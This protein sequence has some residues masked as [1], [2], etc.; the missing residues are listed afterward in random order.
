MSAMEPDRS[1]DGGDDFLAAEF[2]LGV[3]P[4][5][6]LAALA[7]RAE[8]DPAFARAVADW[9]ERLLPLADGYAPA[10]LPPG[11]KQTLD[12]HL[13]GIAGPAPRPGF[14]ASLAL[15]RGLAGTA[16]AAFLLALIVPQLM[17]KPAPPPDVMASLSAKASDVHYMAV[18]DAGTGTVRLAHMSGTPAAGRVFELWVVEGSAA[19]VSL[20]VIPTGAMVR[21]PISDAF[22]AL[23]TSRAQMA[24]SLEPPG[25]SPTGQ[26][27]GAVVA[28]GDLLDI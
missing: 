1:D 2:A 6:E 25:G 27:T 21:I 17:P 12:R 24:I 11:V 26:P 13:F 23:L 8:M 16:M 18:Y 10:D 14:W 15:W 5:V 7:R 22:R 4:G 9:E 19:P 3:L 20:G 28:V